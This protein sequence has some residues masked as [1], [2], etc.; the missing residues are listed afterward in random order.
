[1]VWL[2]WFPLTSASEQICFVFLAALAQLSRLV[3][4]I[5]SLAYLALSLMN[6]TI[7]WL[8]GILYL[9]CDLVTTLIAVS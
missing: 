3:M 6:L 9:G 4:V 5:G 8:M 7:R 1:M 2:G